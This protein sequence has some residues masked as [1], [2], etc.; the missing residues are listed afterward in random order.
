MKCLNCNQYIT[1]HDN[2]L[3]NKKYVNLTLDDITLKGMIYT[4]NGLREYSNNKQCQ[5]CNDELTLNKSQLKSY[6]KRIT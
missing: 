1:I 2:L 4:Q 5:V 6:R 3:P